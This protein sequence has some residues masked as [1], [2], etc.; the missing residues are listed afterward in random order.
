MEIRSAISKTLDDPGYR[1]SAKKLQAR[2]GAAVVWR[3]RRM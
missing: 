1:N 2:I 3:S